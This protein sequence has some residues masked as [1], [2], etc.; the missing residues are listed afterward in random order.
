MTEIDGTEV[1]LRDHVDREAAPSL[2]VGS[3][4]SAL[5]LASEID[6]RRFAVDQSPGSLSSQKATAEVGS[7]VTPK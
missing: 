3:D 2:S 1:R 4:G 6:R 5:I 7:S